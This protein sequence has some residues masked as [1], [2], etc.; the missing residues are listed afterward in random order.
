MVLLL[1]D[2]IYN[3]FRWMF[4]HLSSNW[5]T[6]VVQNTL[7]LLGFA[8]QQGKL[9]RTIIYST[10]RVTANNQESLFFILFLLFF[11]IIASYYVWT[12]A[13]REDDRDQTKLLLHCIMIITSVVP[14][15]LPME[16]S[17]AVNNSLA[18]LSKTYVFCTEPFRIPVAGR[19]DVA[20]FDKVFHY[21]VCV[22]ITS[23]ARLG[24]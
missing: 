18:A 9:V 23:A 8:T 4:G 3:E 17:M 14:P 2:I 22:I 10:D 12:T 19:I 21:C 1:W 16:L 6:N 11:A 20:C 24:L 13:S 7:N 15:E 5:Y